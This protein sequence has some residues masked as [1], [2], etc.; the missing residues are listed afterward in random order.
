MSQFTKDPNRRLSPRHQKFV[1]EYMK[2]GNGARAAVAVGYSKKNAS[3]LAAKLIAQHAGIQRAIA[4]ARGAS[5]ERAAY[6]LKAAMEETDRAIQEAKDAKQYSAVAKM[7]EH[8]AKLNG[9]LIEKHDHRVLG[10]FQINIIGVDR[11]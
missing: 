5:A 11:E 8:K 9:L 7:I 2:D 1:E 3:S 6:N 4:E 10:G